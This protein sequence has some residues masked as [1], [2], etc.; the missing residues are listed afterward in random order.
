MLQCVGRFSNSEDVM[1]KAGWF[2]LINFTNFSYLCVVV[3]VHED[4][5]I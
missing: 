2:D 5:L 3:K 4:T 1:C